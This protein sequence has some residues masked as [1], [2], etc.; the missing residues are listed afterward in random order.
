MMTEPIRAKRVAVLWRHVTGYLQAALRAML[1]DE[2]VS[3]L[4]VQSVQH[5]NARFD[6]FS[7][8]RCAFVDL[9][10]LPA[11]DIHWLDRLRSC[12]TVVAVNTGV[13]ER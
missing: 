3:L 10:E 8:R 1:E 13:F 6:L 7:H 5:P 4:V 11:D 12:D 2:Q 9:S